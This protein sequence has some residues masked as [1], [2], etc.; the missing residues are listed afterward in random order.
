MY[1]FELTLRPPMY[2]HIDIF[3]DIWEGIKLTFFFILWAVTAII[4]ITTLGLF[5]FLW[6]LMLYP[7]YKKQF[8]NS[9]GLD[10]K[11]WTIMAFGK[12]LYKR[13]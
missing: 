5:G 12:V 1:D 10:K 7:I 6:K 13:E 3:E 8:N 11:E 2:I 9:I 4:N